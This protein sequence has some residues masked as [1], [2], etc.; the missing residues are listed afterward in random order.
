M[1][2]QRDDESLRKYWDMVGEAPK[3][4]KGGKVGYIVKSGLLFRIFDQ[5]R[6]RNARKQLLVPGKLT[7]KVLAVAHDG[8]LSGHCGIK[9]TLER[10]ASNFYWPD[11][12]NDV[13][14]YCRSCDI[15]KKA[16]QEEYKEKHHCRGCQ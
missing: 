1:E 8:L 2:F 14:R 9:R 3:K 4:V 15:S 12:P 5:R 16:S 10:V 7:D 11:M 6:N 13:R